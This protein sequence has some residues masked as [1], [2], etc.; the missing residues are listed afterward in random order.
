MWPGLFW[1]YQKIG[2]LRLQKARSTRDLKVLPP[3]GFPSGFSI[4][5]VF[6]VVAV[7]TGRGGASCYIIK[8]SVCAR[9]P[10]PGTT[11]QA[12]HVGMR[13]HK[14]PVPQQGSLTFPRVI[15]SIKLPLPYGLTAA[16]GLC[17][18]F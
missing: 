2:I 4:P 1:A 5:A 10:V 3:Q 8:A 17:D 7:P 18:I 6:P 14:H 13:G 11:V 12:V 16:C 15:L 9:S